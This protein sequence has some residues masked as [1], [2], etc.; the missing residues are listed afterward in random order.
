MN[1]VLKG[2]RGVWKVQVQLL[3]LFLDDE[4]QASAGAFGERVSQYIQKRSVEL[5]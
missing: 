4:F 2:I 1:E 5:S 3:G